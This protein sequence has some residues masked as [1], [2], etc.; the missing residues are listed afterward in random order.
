MIIEESKGG[1]M[2]QVADA[3]LHQA[4]RNIFKIIKCDIVYNN[5]EVMTSGFGNTKK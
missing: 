3:D 4:P 2:P 1:E 5:N